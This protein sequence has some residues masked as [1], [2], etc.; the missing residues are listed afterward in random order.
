MQI[1]KYTVN[2]FPSFKRIRHKPRNNS[3]FKTIHDVTWLL[4]TPIYKGKTP[5]FYVC[6][7]DNPDAVEYLISKGAKVNK[8]TNPLISAIRNDNSPIA[9]ILISNGINISMK[10]DDGILFF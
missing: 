2:R 3:I 5:L 1:R 8:G 6:K 7:Q 9:K 10:D 4:F